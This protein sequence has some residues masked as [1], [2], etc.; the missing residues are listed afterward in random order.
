MVDPVKM[1]DSQWSQK[2]RVALKTHY[3]YFS[4]RVTIKMKERHIYTAEATVFIY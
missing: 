2:V 3:S 4:D 1:K